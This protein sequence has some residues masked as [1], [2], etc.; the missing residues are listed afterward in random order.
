M[1]R[2]AERV[3]WIALAL[4]AAAHLVLFLYVVGRRLVYPFDLE[5]MEGGMLLHAKR[6]AQGQPIYGPP[7]IDFVP[8]LY[9]PL[10]PAVVAILGKLFGIG[11][12]LGRFVSLASLAAALVLGYRAARKT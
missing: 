12:A 10:Y 11:Y 3:L 2:W 8:Y 9:T 4:L 7:S 1:R 6:I 5:W